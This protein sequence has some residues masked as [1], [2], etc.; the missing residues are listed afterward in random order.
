M[1]MLPVGTVPIRRNRRFDM[2]HRTAAE[3]DDEVLA[4]YAAKALAWDGPTCLDGPE[5]RTGSPT[6]APE[7]GVVFGYPRS[8]DDLLAVSNYSVIAESAR[9][10]AGDNAD[11]D[12]RDN[13]LGHWAFGDIYT[14]E[15]RV[16]EPGTEGVYT[17]AFCEAVSLLLAL[18]DCA[19]LDESDYHARE[20]E[21][22]EAAFDDAVR[23]ACGLDNAE[24]QKQV[25]IV[26]WE[27][28]TEETDGDPYSII[29]GDGWRAEDVNYD[30]IREWYHKG[31]EEMYARRDAAYWGDPV[32]LHRQ[33]R[34]AAE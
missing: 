34:Q 4:K 17:A 10:A 21:A 20:N 13:S 27:L 1:M 11:R 15:V 24:T 29:C 22:L 5:N 23:M 12:V 2:Q 28:L 25:R 33:A 32:Y 3:L 14:L 8:T 19:V 9:A 6:T 18:Q 30:A 16:Y 26:M 31:R 7:F